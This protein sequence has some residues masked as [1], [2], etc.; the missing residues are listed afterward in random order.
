MAGT[1]YKPVLLGK[2]Y[3]G[4]Q[5]S[6]PKVRNETNTIPLN[7]YGPRVSLTLLELLRSTTFIHIIF[8]PE[9]TLAGTS[10]RNRQNQVI[11]QNTSSNKTTK[12]N[13]IPQKKYGALVSLT[14]FTISH[15]NRIIYTIFPPEPT[16][17][18]TTYLPIILG[19]YCIEN[20]TSRTKSEEYNQYLPPVEIW[21]SSLPDLNRINP[22]YYI[23]HQH[24]PS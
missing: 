23:H 19:K 1:T 5:T 10:F 7:K 6:P 16:L 2:N 18:G 20:Q 22:Q 24:I 4:N 9:P 3:I 17:A 13:S 15:K 21:A 12:T 8:P 14:L 11:S